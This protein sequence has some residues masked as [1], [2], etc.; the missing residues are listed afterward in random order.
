MRINNDGASRL[1]EATVKLWDFQE[2]ENQGKFL[3]LTP[4]DLN[5]WKMDH[6]IGKTLGEDSEQDASDRIILA[7]AWEARGPNKYTVKIQDAMIESAQT[8]SYTVGE[9][10]RWHRYTKWKD[11]PP[12]GIDQEWM[13]T[14]NEVTKNWKR[15]GDFMKINHTA[16][17]ALINKEAAYRGSSGN[18]MT[19]TRD[20]H[21]EA[22]SYDNAITRTRGLTTQGAKWAEAVKHYYLPAPDT[23]EERHGMT[24]LIGPMEVLQDYDYPN[25]KQNIQ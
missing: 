15:E 20:H 22:I 25:L 9:K 8:R 24:K 23:N 3:K 12:R 17:M 2:R 7:S 4:Q 18:P 21:N 14:L 13:D 5:L 19:L 10:A 16:G 6:E 1:A 11:I